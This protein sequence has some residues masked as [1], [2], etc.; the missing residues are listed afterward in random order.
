MRLT[1]FAT[2][3]ALFL[4]AAPALADS[5]PLIKAELS[6]FP[7]AKAQIEKDLKEGKRY[8]ELTRTQ[9][10]DVIAALER[11]EDALAGISAVSELSDADKAK[12]MTD[13]EWVNVL[14]TKAADDSR[15]ICRQER[16]TGSHRPTTQCRTLA[17]IKRDQESAK[18]VGRRY[19]KSHMRN[20]G[21]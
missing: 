14:L 1:L 13:Q 3:V 12:L 8:S 2:V 17:Q 21:N 20:P 19:Q 18:D 16:K 15:L 11:I 7:S 10:E 4:A 5:A 6:E 9:R